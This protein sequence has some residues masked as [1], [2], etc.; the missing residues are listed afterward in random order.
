[1]EP[2]DLILLILMP[3]ILVGLIFYINLN[4]SITGA[5]TAEQQKSNV[6]GVYS[7]MPSFKAKIDYELDDYNKINVLLS[8]MLDCYKAGNEIGSCLEQIQKQ[9]ESFE[10]L[11]GCDSGAE[12]IFYDFAEFYQNCMDS[13]DNNCV[14]RKNF[15]LLTLCPGKNALEIPIFSRSLRP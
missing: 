11:L 14:C 4:P 10:W 1:M 12:K 5:A 8:T 15:R 6:I 13:D 9:D 7:I 2:K 3:F